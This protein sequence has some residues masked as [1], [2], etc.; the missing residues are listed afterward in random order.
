MPAG[1]EA[2]PIVSV[3]G[4][5]SRSGKTAL[6]VTLL[7]AMPRG[8]A[9]AVKFTTTEDVFERCPRGAPCVVCDIDVPFRIVQDEGTLREPGTDTDRLAAAGASRVV[10]A[11]ARASAAT[12]AWR[13]VSSIVEEGLSVMEGSTV[14]GLAR[15]ELRL[16]VVHPFLSPDR[17][18][19]GSDALIE[20]ATL[21]VVNR[22][23]AEPRPPDRGVLARVEQARGGGE[24]RVADVT[25]PL[26]T[27]APDVQEAL[28]ALRG[29]GVAAR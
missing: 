26:H 23:A 22:P 25:Q 3:S 21:V 4:A 8:A 9:A 28:D 2:V 6:A 7:G 27:W 19:P 13:R 1:V 10:W 11:I 16:F 12:A 29:R 5:C 20:G 15:P 14:V 24:V 17:W 18:K